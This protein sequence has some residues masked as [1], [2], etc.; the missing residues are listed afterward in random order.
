MG[1]DGYSGCF[2]LPRAHSRQ[3]QAK[4]GRQLQC[5]IRDDLFD[6][7]LHMEWLLDHGTPRSQAG[8]DTGAAGRLGA[9]RMEEDGGYDAI[10]ENKEAN[11]IVT[12]I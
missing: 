2:S 12:H 1:L 9:Q 11:Q 4:T 5:T 8:V 6:D 7:N 10:I 3:Q